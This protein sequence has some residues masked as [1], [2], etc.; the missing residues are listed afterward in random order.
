[1]WNPK[2]V[3]VAVALPFVG[4]CFG[5]WTGAGIGACIVIFIN[6]GR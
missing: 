1:M 3:I 6:L 2:G 4:Y 5:G